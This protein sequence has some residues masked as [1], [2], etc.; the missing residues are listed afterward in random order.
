MA[1]RSYTGNA[2][3]RAQVDRLTPGGTIEAS[4]LFKVTI[5]G[6]TVSVAAGGTTVAAVTAALAAALAAE[7]AA[8]FQEIT[9]ADATTHVSATANEAGKPFT[10]T[11]ATT[12]SNGAAA[13]GQTFTL[14]HPTPNSSPS[15][16]GDAGNWSSGTLPVDGDTIVFDLSN[17]SIQWRL[18][19]LADVTPAATYVR[20]GFN[21]DA[22]LAQHNGS[23]NEY[24][25]TAVTLAGGPLYVDCPSNLLRFDL[26]GASGDVTVNGTGQSST[27]PALLLRGVSGTVAINRG[28]VGIAFYPGET[29]SLDLKIGYQQS[30]ESDAQV[31]CGIGCTLGAVEKSGGTLVVRSATTSL[32]S[33][34]G[35]ATVEEGAHPSL[36]IF[37]GTCF[38]NSTGTLGGAPRVG[39]AGVLDFSR[40]MRTKTVTNPIDVSGP[41]PAERVRDPHGVVGNLRIDCNDA[42]FLNLGT[43]VRITRGAVS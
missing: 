13:D 5:N 9:W 28:S 27:T 12:E 7:T 2:P 11:L 34:G 26:G 19:A 32:V 6:K 37:G 42:P 3:L 41:D 14:T 33:R 18:D 17:V 36:S 25:P 40:D 8:E 38:Y 24:R 39:P 20:P 29:A 10:L 35:E 1:T 15:D 30:V 4:D 23:Y 31:V 43:N 22:G 21:G 16:L